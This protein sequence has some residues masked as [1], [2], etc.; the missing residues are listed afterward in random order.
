LSVP[1][2]IR[3]PTFVIHETFDDEAVVVN[4]RSGAYFSVRGSALGLWERIRSGAT[5]TELLDPASGGARDVTILLDVL[6]IEGLIE[7]A[8]GSRPP[9]VNGDL[10]E[11]LAPTV[12]AGAFEKFTDVEG[13]LMLDPI[14]D[15][16]AEG[17]PRPGP[18]A[19]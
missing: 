4:L 9:H 2:P 19:N 7:G 11:R 8:P 10:A 6:R 17:W 1:E 15:V 5:S 16:G 12:F 14:H 3:I 13:L 18:E